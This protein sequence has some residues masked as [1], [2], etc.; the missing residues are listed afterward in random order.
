MFDDGRDSMMD[1]VDNL[2]GSLENLEDSQPS[3]NPKGG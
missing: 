2:A 3:N 1:E